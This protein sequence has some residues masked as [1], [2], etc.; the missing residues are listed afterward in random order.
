MAAS[1]NFSKKIVVE[2]NYRFPVAKCNF[3]LL[4]NIK[5]P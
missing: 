4:K 2:Y 5:I 3:P 1:F